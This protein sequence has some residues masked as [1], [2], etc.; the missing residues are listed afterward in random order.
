MIDV[1]CNAKKLTDTLKTIQ[2]GI[3]NAIAWGINSTSKKTRTEAARELKK[4]MGR[5]VP[6]KAA[7]S[8]IRA[9]NVAKSAKLQATITLEK[10]HELSLKYFKPKQTAA[11]VQVQLN[12][13][14]KGKAG[15]TQ[16]AHAFVAMRLGKKVFLRVGKSRLPIK[17]QF[18]PGPGD[19]IESLGLKEKSVALIKVELPKRIQRKIR[20]VTLKASGGLRGKQLT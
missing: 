14:I 8:L 20:F 9:R 2:D 15:R 12:R 17:E 10:G 4:E 3:P 18:G 11:G 19:L 5:Y 7:K 6:L 1:S 13:A 16:I